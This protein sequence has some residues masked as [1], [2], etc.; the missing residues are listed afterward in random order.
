MCM[1]Q[2]LDMFAYLVTYPI[3]FPCILIFFSLSLWKN[4]T[5]EF[6]NC[7]HFLLDIYFQFIRVLSDNSS[8]PFLIGFNHHYL[9][10]RYEVLMKAI[11]TQCNVSGQPWKWRYPGTK[12]AFMSAVALIF[13]PLSLLKTFVEILTSGEVLRGAALVKWL[14]HASTALKNV[15]CV[16]LCGPIE[17]LYPFHHQ[18]VG[19]QQMENFPETWSWTSEPLELWGIK[20]CSVHG[21]LLTLCNWFKM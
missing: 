18:A 12:V 15:I 10:W 19:P 20:V 16:L 9:H 13:I 3:E 17:F 2:T 21:I 4:S 5:Q 1:L 6:C 7:N 11:K 8:D 14:D